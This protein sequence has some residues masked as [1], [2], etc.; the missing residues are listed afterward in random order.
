MY[1]MASNIA[2][3]FNNMDDGGQST[4]LCIYVLYISKK[5][6]YTLFMAEKS[7]LIHRSFEAHLNL[8]LSLQ[9]E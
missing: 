9:F 3:N 2:V 7:I 8:Q 4:E 1:R 5:Q 6:A